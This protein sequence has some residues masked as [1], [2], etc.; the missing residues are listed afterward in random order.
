[1]RCIFKSGLDVMYHDKRSAKTKG[2]NQSQRSMKS[3]NVKKSSLTKFPK[4][5]LK[6]NSHCLK[7]I[8]VFILLDV[9]Y[10]WNTILPW[11]WFVLNLRR[12]FNLFAISTPIRTKIHPKPQLAWAKVPK[13]TCR[14]MRVLVHSC[15]AIKNHH[16]N[17]PKHNLE[18]PFAFWMP[19]VGI[20]TC[21]SGFSN[22]M[23]NPLK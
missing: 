23:Y 19:S 22:Y 8:K 15:H 3:K 18:N 20:W 17:L 16:V 10:N 13:C 5:H 21:I 6:V 1:M 2:Q 4:F 7:Y 9:S 14:Y 12:Y 11:I